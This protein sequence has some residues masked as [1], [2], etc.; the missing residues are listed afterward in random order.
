MDSSGSSIPGCGMFC[1]FR[2][3]RGAFPNYQFC[4]NGSIGGKFSRLQD[5][6]QEI[7]CFGGK[8][9]IIRHDGGPRRIQIFGNS[10]VFP[11]D[12]RNI[13]RYPQMQR[14]QGGI[15]F[16]RM[17]RVDADQGGASFPD[18]FPRTTSPSYTLPD[19]K[20]S[21]PVPL[22]SPSRHSPS[23]TN[24]PRESNCF[25]SPSR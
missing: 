11:V 2:R 17:N 5:F 25:P 9:R 20:N 6:R 1:F 3:R 14:M 15:D 19:E 21:F 7:Q 22:A 13:I 4:L 16:Q 8:F 24:F 10:V 18:R 12:K 23:Y